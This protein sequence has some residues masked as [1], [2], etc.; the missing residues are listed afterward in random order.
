MWFLLSQKLQ[1]IYILTAQDKAYAANIEKSLGQSTTA[2]T[3]LPTAMPQALPRA[4]MVAT[5]SV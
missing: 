1:W 5:A 3:A 2:A 4:A